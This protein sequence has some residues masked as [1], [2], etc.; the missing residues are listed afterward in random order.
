MDGDQWAVIGRRVDSDQTMYPNDS[1][2]ASFNLFSNWI[3]VVAAFAGPN[4]S[5]HAAKLIVI[6]DVDVDDDD[7][8]NMV[9]SAEL[10][11]CFWNAK[12]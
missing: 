6:N 11:M 2:Y 5:S 12:W 3:F 8:D 1:S 4:H 7:D 9:I 10:N